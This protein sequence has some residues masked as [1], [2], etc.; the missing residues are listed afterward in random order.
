MSYHL[1]CFVHIRLVLRVV[2]ARNFVVEARWLAIPGYTHQLPILMRGW[3]GCPVR[4]MLV[5]RVA[6]AHTSSCLEIA[7]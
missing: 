2:A 5:L 3:T 1:P 6:A 4:G 7:D